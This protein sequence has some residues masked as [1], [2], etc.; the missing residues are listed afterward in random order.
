[1]DQKKNFR[2]REIGLD[3]EALAALDAA[4]AM[5][6]GPDRTAANEKSRRSTKCG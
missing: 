6:H 3:A 4:R 5:P 2:R 1:M